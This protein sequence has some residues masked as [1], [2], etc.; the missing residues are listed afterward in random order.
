MT[1]EESKW[2]VHAAAKLSRKLLL[3]DVAIAKLSAERLAVQTREKLAVKQDLGPVTWLEIL[4]EGVRAVYQ[5]ELYI[6]EADGDAGS[7][8]G[9]LFVALCAEYQFVG[10]LTEE[11]ES[12]IPH[13]LG[14]SGW[15]HAWPYLRAEVQNLTTKLGLPP[16]VL[17]PLYAGETSHVP[18]SKLDRGDLQVHKASESSHP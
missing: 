14:I 1:D 8:L 3:R 11:E 12:L 9:R 7:V 16:Y 15:M 17:P 4:G 18:V 13:F 10:E 2:D 5:C 6:G